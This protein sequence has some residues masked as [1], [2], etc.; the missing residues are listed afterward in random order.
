M[1]DPDDAYW[2]DEGRRSAVGLTPDRFNMLMRKLN[3][4]ETALKMWLM[5]ACLLLA[6]I[7]GKLWGF[8]ERL[9]SWWT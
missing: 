8:P 9:W 7:L 6:A 4:I 1:T 5:L 2:L 3:H